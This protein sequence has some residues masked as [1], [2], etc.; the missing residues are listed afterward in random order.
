MYVP[1]NTKIKAIITQ[2]QKNTEKNKQQT[3]KTI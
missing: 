2:R 3:K 1:K